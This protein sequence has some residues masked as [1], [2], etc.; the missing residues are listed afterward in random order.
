MGLG[1]LTKGPVAV[2]LPFLVSALFFLSAHRFRDWVRAVLDPAGWLLFLLLVLPWHLA[3]YVQ[4]GPGFLQGFYVHH[5]LE[6]FSQTF[7][8][9]GGSIGYYFLALPLSLLPFTGW[10][11]SVLGSWRQAGHE[12]LDRFLWLWFAVVFVLF[13]LSET[14]LPHYLLYGAT[15]LFVL[16]ARYRST[17]ASPSLTY[18]P[19]SVMLVVFLLLPELTAATVV[20]YRIG[21]PSFSVYRG[22][23]TPHRRP[24]PGEV[25]FTRIDRLA[26][27]AALYP[28]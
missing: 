28:H 5:N 21:M 26:E 2:L 4:K 18:L 27:L 17:L 11:V 25:A 10:F 24:Q 1:T 8:G 20:A 14:Q 19:S 16:M 6:R 12:T 22:G 23:A 7:E 15:P 3:V 9:H 13:S